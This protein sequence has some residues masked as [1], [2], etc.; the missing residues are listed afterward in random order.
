MCFWRKK[1]KVKESEKQ[2]VKEQSKVEDKPKQEVKSQPVKKEEKTVKKESV[3]QEE[4]PVS[5]PQQSQKYHISQ[6]ND[7]KSEFYKQWRVRKSG[8]KK[9]IKF[10]KTQKEAI[11]Y[12]KSLAKNAD[13]DIVIHKVDG[14]IRKQKY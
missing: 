5:E 12:A 10:F 4:K 3:K 8:S 1:K 7:D 2:E 14:K 13:T 11:D 9:T 6:N